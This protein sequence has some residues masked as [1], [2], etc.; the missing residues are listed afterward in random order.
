MK[1][2]IY[3][4]FE[5]QV[6]SF[7]RFGSFDP[8][9]DHPPS[10]LTP[11]AQNA[12][13]PQSG[14]NLISTIQTPR[15]TFLQKNLPRTLKPGRFFHARYPLDYDTFYHLTYFLVFYRFCLT[16]GRTTRF[17]VQTPQLVQNTFQ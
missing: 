2:C 16:A 12:Q 15:M 9:P 8:P 10:P 13:G 6:I 5:P 14:M 11:G 3:T 17:H 1:K 4:N 7:R